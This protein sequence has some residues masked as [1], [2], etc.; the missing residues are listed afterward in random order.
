MQAMKQKAQRGELFL[1][2][3]VGYVKTGDDR[4]EKDSDRRV[5]EAICLASHRSALSEYIV[6]LRRALQLRK[7]IEYQRPD[8]RFS[9]NAAVVRIGAAKHFIHE[10]Q[11]WPRLV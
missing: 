7:G 1:A 2:V 6:M 9:A 8:N 10:K 11:H 3:A 4:I 5:Q